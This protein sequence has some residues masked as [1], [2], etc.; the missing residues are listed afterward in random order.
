MTRARAMRL[1]A[2]ALAITAFTAACGSDGD[3]DT[4]SAEAGAGAAASPMESHSSMSPSSGGGGD[5]TGAAAATSAAATTR[6][7][8]TAQLEEHVYLAGIATGTALGKGADSADFKAAAGALDANSVALAETVGSVYGK[9]GGDQFLALW[10]KHIGFFV[11]YTV[12]AATNDAAKKTKAVQDLD[13]YRQD[14]GA[15]LESATEGELPKAAVADELK[16]H[17]ATLAAAVDA[18]AAKDPKQ[19]AL[20][21]EA[22]AH[23]PMTAAVLA[24]A[25]DA[26]KDLAGDTK[27][28]ASEARA[29]LTAEL[30][31]HVY[32][33]GI[34]TGTALDKGA[35]S[36][37]FKAAA[38]A[39]D[40]NS[41]ELATIVGS[42]YGKAGGDQ[43]L[44]LW[45]KHIGFFVD[46]TVGAATKDAAKK[47]KAVQDLDGYRADFGAFLESAT[48][49]KLT[50]A[51]VA[52]ELG[53]HVTSLAAAVDAQAAKDPKQFELLRAA[54]DH[55][56][57]TAE[58]L[59]TA[60]ADQ[61]SLAG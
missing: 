46:Y 56:P 29:A 21:K 58:V 15:F 42:V 37:E 53:P 17:V 51:A 61:K 4:T 59:A 39:L 19:F 54:A 38:G 25:I 36:A 32:L 45:R 44:A 41:V 52:D 24:G 49:G 2:A 5:L 47:T 57:M 18:Q 7:I 50:K 14:F 34:A 33:A 27:S 9:A 40:A 43:F 1:T 31:E 22:A 28:P 11:D 48:E 20:L 60:I 10:R 30:E 26:Q 12:G 6:A 3:D 13:G 55:M 35:D 23:M 16:P 8:L